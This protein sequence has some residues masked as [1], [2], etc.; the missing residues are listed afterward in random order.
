MTIH[1][2]SNQSNAIINQLI[3]A[4]NA[5]HD[6]PHRAVSMRAPVG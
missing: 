4:D 3:S 2:L 5:A 1:M 6:H